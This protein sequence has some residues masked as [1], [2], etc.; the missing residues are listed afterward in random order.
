MPGHRPVP[1]ARRTGRPRRNSHAHR[2]A[3]CGLFGSNDN[4]NR[5][6]FELFGLGPATPLSWRVRPTHSGRNGGKHPDLETIAELL[7]FG[8]PVARSNPSQ[9]REQRPALG[10]RTEDFCKF[11]VKPHDGNRTSLFPGKG[12]VVVFPINVFRVQKGEVRLGSP[13][14]P[15]QLIESFPFGIGF[16]VH[17]RSVF[18]QGNGP[19]LLECNLRPLAL[20]DDRPPCFQNR[21]IEGEREGSARFNSFRRILGNL[22]NSDKIVCPICREERKY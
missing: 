6:A 13:D 16:A 1:A 14:V 20:D 17:H 3:E 19:F 21:R 22:R 2:S 5:E 12:N 7:E 18:V 8:G 11:L 10:E 15:R 4:L 9:I